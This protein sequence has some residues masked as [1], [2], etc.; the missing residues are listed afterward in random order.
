MAIW[1]LI[2]GLLG[3][4]SKS[5]GASESGQNAGAFSSIVNSM[6]NKDTGPSNR[7][8]QTDAF[9][10]KSMDKGFYGHM[11]VGKCKRGKV[12]IIGRGC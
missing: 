8:G 4:G 7:P 9:G 10:L 5:D 6:S 11:T 3:G 2:A 1:G 12:K